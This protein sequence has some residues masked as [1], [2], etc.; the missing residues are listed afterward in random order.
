MSTPE[1]IANTLENPEIIRT[2]ADVLEI[3]QHLKIYGSYL[4]QFESPDKRGEITLSRRNDSL[5]AQNYVVTALY[6]L[7]PPERTFVLYQPGTEIRGWVVSKNSYDF[8]EIHPSRR[9]FPAGA[10]LVLVPPTHYDEMVKVPVHSN[11]RPDQAYVYFDQAGHISLDDIAKDLAS[12]EGK[13]TLQFKGTPPG[14]IDRIG[15]S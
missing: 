10:H 12:G 11:D 2:Q 14:M 5:F 7:R 9:R 15:M 13:L 1:N 4:D 3:A 8:H 6:R